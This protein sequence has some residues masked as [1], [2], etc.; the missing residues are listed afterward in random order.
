MLLP[1]DTTKSKVFKEYEKACAIDGLS[2]CSKSHF[3]SLWQK[4]LPYVRIMKP[5]TDLCNTCQ[6]MQ[7]TVSLTANLPDEEKA[8][9]VKEFCHHLE[10]AKAERKVYNE[11]CKSCH[12]QLPKM[13]LAIFKKCIT[14]LT[15]LSRCITRHHHSNQVLF[16]SKLPKMCCLESAVSLWASKLS[17]RRVLQVKELTVSSATFTSWKYT[18]REKSSFYFML[19]TAVVRIK[20][21]HSCSIWLGA[22]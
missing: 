12:D 22:P 20:I 7:H 10:I 4:Q 11:Q 18:H 6:Q 17:M 1:T 15:T 13:L 2:C 9:K 16:T 19:T 8:S 5:Y 3:L 14:V 21:T